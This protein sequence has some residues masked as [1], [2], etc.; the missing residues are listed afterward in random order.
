MAVLKASSAK[1]SAA[2]IDL[3]RRQIAAAEVAAREGRGS[4]VVDGQMVDEPILIRA[5]RTLALAR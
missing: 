5:R 1:P 4:F 3:A 2:E